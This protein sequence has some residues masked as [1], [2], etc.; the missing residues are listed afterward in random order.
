MKLKYTLAAFCVALLACAALAPQALPLVAIAGGAALLISSQSRVCA[1]SNTVA[2]DLLTI[3]SGPTMSRTA[4]ATLSK[5]GL[6][7]EG[8]SAGGVRVCGASNIPIGV[9]F[10]EGSDVAIASGDRVTIHRLASGEP[11]LALAGGAITR[12]AAV[13]T[14]ASGKVTE[15][16]ATPGTYYLVGYALTA[17]A[18]DGDPFVLNPQAPTAK[19]VS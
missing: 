15:L 14:A 13:Y 3:P 18:A 7:Y 9:A 1:V 6:V 8:S 11:C 4:E 12:G 17:A 16:T 10:V 19:V 5:N 2:E